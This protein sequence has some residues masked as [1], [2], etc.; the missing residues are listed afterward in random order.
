MAL[1]VSSKN[2]DGAV[3]PQFDI[4]SGSTDHKYHSN[5]TTG[6]QFQKKIMKEWKSLEKNLP[7]SIF[8][9]V[10]EDRIDLM[11]AAIIGSAGTPYHDGLYF[12]D[13]AFLSDYPARPPL[14][15]YRSFG[16]RINPNLYA[17]GKVCLSLLNTWS[18]KKKEMWNSEQSSVLQILLS[19]QALVLN[20][21]PYF[22]EPFFDGFRG[23]SKWEKRANSYNADVF[24][25]CCKTMLFHQRK[26][27][28]HFESLVAGH[29]K[30]RGSAILTACIAYVNG[31]ARIGHYDSK[32]S[33]SSASVSVEF[34]I[35]MRQLYPQLVAAFAKNGASLGTLIGELQVE[36]ETETETKTTPCKSEKKSNGGVVKRL[37]GKV[38]KAFGLLS[39]KKKKKTTTETGS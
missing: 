29:F 1:S 12:F 6:G 21:K 22:N 9:R 13:I 32:S 19:I 4:V 11:R 18:G 36:V 33:S 24:V 20:E 28:M 35:S 5:T 2:H 26:P 23:W 37:F 30:E 34:K 3:F 38:K 8:V 31:G 15:S 7:D 10:Y 27:P 17:S 25:V 16:F 14:V 39:A